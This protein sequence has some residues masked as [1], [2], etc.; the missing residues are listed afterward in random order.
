MHALQ[1]EPHGI[2]I[3]D[4]AR[5]FASI[6]EEHART[7]MM[8]DVVA[9][10]LEVRALSAAL[11]FFCSLHI[12][13]RYPD[14]LHAAIPTPPSGHRLRKEELPQTDRGEEG[15][16]RARRAGAVGEAV[17]GTSRAAREAGFLGYWPKENRD[18]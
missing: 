13:V 14:E 5:P 1:T 15:I 3:M 16:R 18:A 4:R 9:R 17:S 12:L 6:D 7:R 8:R 10:T 11:A 2:A